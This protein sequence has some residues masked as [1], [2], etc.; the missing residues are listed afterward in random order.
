[1][2][3]TGKVKKFVDTSYC[4]AQSQLQLNL[5]GLSL[6]LFSVSPATEPA[7]QNIAVN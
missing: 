5:V 1:M 7:M 2:N 3:K 4:Q 6:D